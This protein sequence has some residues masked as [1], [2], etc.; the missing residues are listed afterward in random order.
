MDYVILFDEDTP[1]DLIKAIRPDVLVK[2]ADYT[3]EQ[4]VGHDIVESYGGT[5]HLMPVVN[6]MS[7]TTIINRIK[8]SF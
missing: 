2:G 7:T 4:V 1:L 8:D 6:N 5:V 3:V